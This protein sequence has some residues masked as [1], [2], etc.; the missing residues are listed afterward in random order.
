MPPL[1]SAAQFSGVA[2]PTPTGV[3]TINPSGA[4]NAVNLSLSDGS[5]VQLCDTLETALRLMEWMR[6]R[7]QWMLQASDDVIVCS[8]SATKLLFLEAGLIQ[9]KLLASFSPVYLGG[10][11]MFQHRTLSQMLSFS[12][13]AESV[14]FAKLSSSQWQGNY[15]LAQAPSIHALLV[16]WNFLANVTASNQGSQLQDGTPLVYDYTA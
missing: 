2:R 3:A 4:S 14:G 15:D 11:V 10:K 12:D 9:Q 5:T 13:A 1:F 6:S 8:I 7:N 16:D